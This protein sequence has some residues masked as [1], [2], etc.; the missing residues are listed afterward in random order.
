MEVA[1]N[2]YRN[3]FNVISNHSFLNRILRTLISVAFL[4]VSIL[5]FDNSNTLIILA[6]FFTIIF[7]SDKYIRTVY[8]DWP[9]KRNFI[10]KLRISDNKIIISTS[11]ITTIQLDYVKELIIFQDYY[12]GYSF[13]NRDLIRNGNALIFL[14]L[15][16]EQTL[17][18]KFNIGNKNQFDTLE[19]LFLLFQ[20]KIPYIKKHTTKDIK[21][22]LKPDL[23]DRVH[24]K[25]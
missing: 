20:N 25:N 5:Y 23:S 11:K 2:L 1:L 9:H 12:K 7:I 19:S 17:T 6:L 3:D 8:P 14:K 10:G 13:N 22:I 15:N 18:L 21:H 16:K 4:I 24:F